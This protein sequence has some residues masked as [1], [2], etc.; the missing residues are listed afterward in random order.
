MINKVT[1]DVISHYLAEQSLPED[2]RFVFSYHVTIKN[3]GEHA[4]QLLSRHWIITDGN[5]K[6]QEVKGPGVIGKTPWLQPGESFQYSSGAI[7]NTMVG[8]MQGSYQMIS[9]DGAEFIADI[10]PFAL[11][12][13]NQVH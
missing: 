11:A 10:Q 7:L 3:E 13:P 4:A 8:T 2:L 1:V 12:V 9:E 5:E 6:V